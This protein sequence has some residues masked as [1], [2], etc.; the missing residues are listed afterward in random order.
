MSS[1]NIYQFGSVTLPQS[2]ATWDDSPSAD[3][4]ILPTLGGHFNAWRGAAPVKLP[5]PL[6]VSALVYKTTNAL[7]GAELDTLRGLVGTRDL[8]WG[9]PFDTTEADRCC[10]ATLRQIVSRGSYKDRLTQR[11]DLVFDVESH[12]NGTVVGG[13]W[14][15]DAGYL[16]DSGLYFDGD[17]SGGV[18]PGVIHLAN[19]GNRT[20]TNCGITYVTG[21]L[22]NNLTFSAGDCKW[23]ISTLAG[24]STLVVDCGSRTVLKNGANFYTLFS[25]DAT[26]ASPYWLEIPPG[27]IDVT[28]T[29]YNV[30]DL[31]AFT[32][33]HGYM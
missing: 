3:T 2:L 19:D 16:F 22:V 21:A 31:V 32:Y 18:A 13:S 12:W 1:M 20:V 7:M 11:V 26:H 4:R 33:A 15:L 28:I 23:K 24:G 29:N 27:G 9:N 25:L 17:V 10:W 5:R 8:L 30:A 14:Y 6:T